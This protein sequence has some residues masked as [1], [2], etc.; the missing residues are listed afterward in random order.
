MLALSAAAAELSVSVRILGAPQQ[1]ARLQAVLAS[2]LPEVSSTLD[3]DPAAPPDDSLGQTKTHSAPDNAERLLVL[4]DVTNP[5]STQVRFTRGAQLL[6]VRDLPRAGASEEVHFQELGL[7]IRSAVEALRVARPE[8]TPITDPAPNEGSASKPAAAE[9]AP[10]SSRDPG[11]AVGATAS[12]QQR[13]PLRLDFQAL[14]AATTYAKDP[15]LL[16]GLGLGLELVL[17]RV[18]LNPGFRLSTDNTTAF[19][20]SEARPRVAH[21]RGLGSVGVERWLPARFGLGVS[22]EN[23]ILDQ[24]DTRTTSKSLLGTLMAELKLPL[25]ERVDGVLGSMLDVQIGSSRVS[26]EDGATLERHRFRLSAYLG[27]AITAAGQR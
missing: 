26:P 14:Y 2:Q 25:S 22:L 9:P 3:A 1:V 24:A 13:T 11:V 20:F 5:I 6:L 10:A 15:S 8:P 23:V 4:V 7:V 18:A 27:L 17:Q 12:P 16:F 19:E 21:L